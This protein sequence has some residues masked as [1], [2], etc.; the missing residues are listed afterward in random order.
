[1]GV[2]AHI[3]VHRAINAQPGS[4]YSSGLSPRQDFT[5]G[6]HLGKKWKARVVHW[7]RWKRDRIL[8]FTI[9]MWKGNKYE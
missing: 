5:G 9:F 7:F 6:Q 3:I 2:I 4:R 8:K 1:M